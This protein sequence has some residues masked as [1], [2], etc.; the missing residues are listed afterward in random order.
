MRSFCE[1]Q[2][3][4][5][6]TKQGLFFFRKKWGHFG[7]LVRTFYKV[8]KFEFYTLKVRISVDSEDILKNEDLMKVKTLLYN[9][10]YFKLSRQF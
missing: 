9:N 5:K 3:F 4:G 2:G 6:T 10:I 8:K 7:N 1:V